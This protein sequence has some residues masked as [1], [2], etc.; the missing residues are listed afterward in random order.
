MTPAAAT[1]QRSPSALDVG[2]TLSERAASLIERDI[3]AGLW[4]PGGRLGVHALSAH[5]AIGATPIREG[6]SRLV[7]RGL[8]LALGQRGFRVADI[9]RADLEDITRV[10]I[11]VETEA[12]RA[13]M[14]DGD[15]I[16]EAGIVAALHR[17]RACLERAPPTMHEGAPEFDALHK[18]FHTALIAACG[19]DRLLRL[20]EDLYL[21]AYR[22]RR[23]MMRR[24][25]SAD[26]LAREH[27][28]LA[29]IVIARRGDAA[30][31]RLT[32]HLRSTLAVVY[33]DSR[34]AVGA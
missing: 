31:E 26:W 13:A 3:I 29:D 32:N 25:E 28:E 20:H 16:W 34:N 11:L 10:R 30:V 1:S 12:L 19:S 18:S 5:Y 8:V 9:S 2:D 22:Y 4:P 27:G 33:D 21:Q 24:I 15:D 17:F 7:A 6:V 14:R 23:V